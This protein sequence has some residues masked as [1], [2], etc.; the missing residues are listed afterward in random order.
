[1]IGKDIIEAL[2]VALPALILQRTEYEH[3]LNIVEELNYDQEEKN[4]D[5]RH[6]VAAI[7]SVENAYRR[8]MDFSIELNNLERKKEK[9]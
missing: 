2:D 3:R 1:M 4:R 7:E 5:A 8:L 9:I 6:L